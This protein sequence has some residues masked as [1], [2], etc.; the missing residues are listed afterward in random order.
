MFGTK[1][2]KLTDNRF[3]FPMYDEKLWVSTPYISDNIL[4]NKWEKMGEIKTKKVIFDRDMVEINQTK[5]FLYLELVDG[6]IYKILYT[7]LK[8]TME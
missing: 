7:I 1:I 4:L 5:Y 8:K 3:I 6:F 2:L